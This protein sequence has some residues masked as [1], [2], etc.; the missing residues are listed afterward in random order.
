MDNI[1]IS[2]KM[3][4]SYDFYIEHNMNMIEWKLNAIITKN[5]KFDE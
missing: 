3:D 2:N 4:M 5:Q 1:T